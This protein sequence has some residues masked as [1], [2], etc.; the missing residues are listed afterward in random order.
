MSPIR[1]FALAA[2]AVCGL[3]LAVADTPA[4]E[5]N[6][7]NKFEVNFTINNF[8]YIDVCGCK[9]KKIRLGS[10]ARRQAYLKQAR[11]NGLNIVM[12]DGGNCL[13]H[14]DK[15]KVKPHEIDQVIEKA[16]VLVES[17]NRMNYR[18]MAVGHYDLVMGL[19]RVREMEELA[20]FPFL[21]ANLVQQESGELVFKPT[22]E[23]EV[24]GTKIGVLGLTL[25]TLQQYYLDKRAPGTKVTDF[26]EAAKKYVPELRKTN[27][28]VIVM[29]HNKVADN[30]RLVQAVPGIDFIID[31]FIELE[32]H[33]LWLEKDQLN[34][35][36]GNTFIARTDSQGARLGVLD[37]HVL[38]GGSPFVNRK[39]GPV[40]AGRSSFEYRQVSIE[41]HWLEDPEISLLVDKFREGTKFVNTERL[42]DFPNKSKY[43]T[44]ST[45]QACHPEQYAFWKETKHADAFASLEETNDQWRQDCISCHVLGYGQ[46]FVAPADAEPYKDVQCESCHG[47]NPLHPTDPV[48]HQWPRVQEKACLVCHNER[49][50]FSK[51]HFH[52]SRQKVACPKMKR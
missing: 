24:N 21:C 31:P 27:D 37:L 49:Q 22:T 26:I 12:L 3:T 11:I 18:A 35:T 46:T 52:S 38:P 9:H 4:K 40:P 20:N 30:K 33:K 32:N 34:A 8:G 25:N 5:A 19:D 23:F 41:P 50:T 36:E 14:N 17:M 48:A 45:C 44:V 2:L 47:L 7:A 43:L 28:I 39:P 13:F 42:P 51:F 10:V 1:I 29:S 6:N 16:K 15:L